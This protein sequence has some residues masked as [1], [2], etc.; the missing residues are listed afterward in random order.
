[1]YPFIITFLAGISTVLGVIPTYFNSKYKDKIINLSL[2][3]S[4]GIMLSISLFSLIPE[5][6]NYMGFS[7][8]NIILLLLF[9][10]IGLIISTY[11]DKLIGKRIENNSLYKLGIVSIIALILHNIPE[12]VTTFLTTSNNFRIGLTLSL[13]IALHNIPEGISIAVPIFYSTK[14][15]MKAIFYTA[16]AGLSEPLGAI[17]TGLF[18]VNYI[19]DMVLGLLFAV[20]AGVMIQI[21]SSKLLPTGNEYNARYSRIFFIIGFIFTIIIKIIMILGGDLILYQK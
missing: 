9:I 16:L 2:S 3:F 1:M 11:T 20:I 6:I 8:I 12:G 21:S 18:L 4:S 15:K 13:A 10:N 7:F 14:S 19:N 17:I 5:S